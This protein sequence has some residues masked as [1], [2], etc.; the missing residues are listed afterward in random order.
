LPPLAR[1]RVTARRDPLAHSHFESRA[2]GAEPGERDEASGLSLHLNR[3]RNR[4]SRWVSSPRPNACFQGLAATL[5][6]R[7]EWIVVPGA[8]A[9]DNMA[10]E[11]AE[12]AAM[13]VRVCK[14]E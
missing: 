4:T 14:T 1:G 7:H 10:P 11:P 9:N 2:C 13:A 5:G 8:T 6:M 12:V 3:R